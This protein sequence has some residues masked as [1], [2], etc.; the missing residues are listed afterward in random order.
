MLYGENSSR[1]VRTCRKRVR[2][3]EPRS[4][5][6]ATNSFHKKLTLGFSRCHAKW[7]AEEFLSD[8]YGL[9]HILDFEIRVWCPQVQK[10]VD[11]VELGL[12]TVKYKEDIVN[13]P[14]VVAD[15]ISDDG[16]ERGH[17]QIRQLNDAICAHCDSVPLSADGISILEIVISADER[18]DGDQPLILRN[19]QDLGEQAVQVDVY[20]LVPSAVTNRAFGAIAV[21]L[22]VDE[23]GRIL[24]SE[25]HMVYL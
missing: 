16:V 25:A 17:G 12:G 5:R 1:A 11:V 22:S 8:Q 4:R 2:N 19:D 24:D 10:S 9:G 18:Q 6:Q 7:P 15:S 3:R 23:C 13:V 21:F 20:R 14:C